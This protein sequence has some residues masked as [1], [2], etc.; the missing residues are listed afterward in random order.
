M[1][2]QRN[3][4]QPEDRQETA[5]EKRLRYLSEEERR[6]WSGV[7]EWRDPLEKDKPESV[8]NDG[9]FAMASLLLGIV[10]VLTL[11]TGYI[12]GVFGAAAVICGIIAKKKQESADTMAAV[13]IILGIIGIGVMLVLMGIS[14]FSKTG[15]P[16]L[17]F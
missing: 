12:C 1:D 15:L 9:K 8:Q 5:E 3:I 7:S 2:T 11:C 6:E 16:F 17:P 13:G 14:R 4:P 10:S